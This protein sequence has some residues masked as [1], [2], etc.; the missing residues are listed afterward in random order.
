VTPEDH[1]DLVPAAEAGR[2]A[3]QMRYSGDDP[4]SKAKGAEYAAMLSSAV[5][6][7]TALEEGIVKRE[8]KEQLE[9]KWKLVAASCKDCHAV[10]RDKKSR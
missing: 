1:P 8:S 10:Y 4:R 3:D 2:L 9:A 7:A 5:D 6:V